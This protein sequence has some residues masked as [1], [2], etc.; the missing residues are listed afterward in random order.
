[1]MPLGEFI[2]PPSYPLYYPSAEE[3]TKQVR[4]NTDFL[5]KEITDHVNKEIERMKIECANVAVETVNS[6]ADTTNSQNQ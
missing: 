4:I 2:D 6:Q 5:M 1:M 3:I